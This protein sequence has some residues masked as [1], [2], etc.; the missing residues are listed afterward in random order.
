MKEALLDVLAN[1]LAA[2]LDRAADGVPRG[3]VLWLDPDREFERL[4]RRLEEALE[5]SKVRLVCGEPKKQFALKLRLLQCDAGN[6]RVVAYL[7]GFS[8]FDLEPRLDGQSPGLWGVFEYRFKGSIWGLLP[9]GRHWEAGTVPEPPSLYAWLHEHG[10]RIADQSTVRTLS[11]GGRDSLLAQYAAANADVPPARWPK[12]LRVRDVQAA[13]GGDP[14]DSL[15]ALLSDPQAAV[16]DWGDRLSVVIERITDSFGLDLNTPADAESTADEVAVQLALNEAWQAYGQPADFP[17]LARLPGEDK[18]RQALAKALREDILPNDEV[19]F[20]YR[21]RIQRLEPQY[22]LAGYG[23]TRSGAPVGLPRLSK[24]QWT[25]FIAG[26]DEACEGGWKK[27]REH[28]LAHQSEV[29]QR[30]TDRWA[31]ED[32]GCHWVTLAQL[33]TLCTKATQANETSERATSAQQ[34]AE[35]YASDWHSIDWSHLVVRDVCSRH[36]DLE[37]VREL[38]DRAY[39]EYV[40]A[41]N[42]HFADLVAGAEIWPPAGLKGV[43]DIRQSVW[44]EGGRRAVIISDALRWDLAQQIAS[45]LASVSVTPV[46][47]TLPSITPFG[48]TAMLPLRQGEPVVKWAGGPTIRDSSGRSLAERAKRKELLTEVLAQHHISVEFIEMTALLRSKKAPSA[49]VIVVFD[50]NIDTEGHKLPENFPASAR[51][52]VGDI[53]R[54]IEKLHQLGIPTVHVLTDHGFLLLPPDSVESLGA[55]SIPE[56]LCARREHRWAALKAEAQ[57]D[58]LIRLKLPLSPD[59]GTLAFPKGIR[60]LEKPEAYMHGGI[61]I[62]ECL[63]PHI[64]ASAVVPIARVRPVLAVSQTR[65]TTGT[66]SYSLKPAPLTQAP[67]GGV[68]PVFVRVVVQ[69]EGPP[70]RDVSGDRTEELRQDVEE[71]R[72]ALFLESGLALPTGSRLVMRCLDRD[73]QEEYGAVPLTLEVNWD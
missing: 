34:L 18:H 23:S 48:M 45:G 50:T 54:S 14:R 70:T 33:I 39:F 71:I 6:E 49:Q 20:R 21:N 57:A 51:K 24:G 29:L 1:D 40:A 13:L 65:L 32:D 63:I 53:R 68:E 16:Q 44:L 7:P 73:T 17:F 72:G 8:R 4:A 31:T 36:P 27:A 37:H 3:V 62:Q 12:P 28:L 22:D 26:L 69:T 9:E 38:A 15:R 55:P 56:A 67:L 5:R 35:A 43:T 66:I 10:V 52:L 64:V 11:A 19:R 60:T 42:D 25:R 2:W 47:S 30:Q 41:I 46:M 58:G 61:S 59:A